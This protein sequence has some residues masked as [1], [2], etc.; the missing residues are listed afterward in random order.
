VQV[1]R[2]LEQV[3]DGV[4]EGADAVP[5]L[6]Y[7]HECLLHEILCFRPVVRDEQERPEQ[8]LALGLEEFLEGE[9]DSKIFR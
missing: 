7:P 3:A 2:R 6:P 8:P 5:T 4:I 1:Q 9:R